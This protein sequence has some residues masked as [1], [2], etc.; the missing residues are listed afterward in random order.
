MRKSFFQKVSLSLVAALVIS[1]FHGTVLAQAAN[2]KIVKEGGGTAPYYVYVN[3]S[4]A[5]Y[6]LSKEDKSATYVWDIVEGSEYAAINSKTGV[7]TAKAPGY[8]VIRCTAQYDDGTTEEVTKKIRIVLRSKSISTNK[9]KDVTLLEDG[10][11]VFETVPS[12][13]TSTDVFRYTSSDESVAKVDYKTGEVT[14]VG[15]GSATIDV[16]GKA[17]VYADHDSK[18]N[19]KTSVDVQ[20]LPSVVKDVAQLKSALKADGT[21]TIRIATDAED[22]FTIPQREYSEKSLVVNAPNAD[23]SNY[24]TFKEVLIEDIKPTTWYENGIGNVLRCKAPNAGI[25]AGINSVVKGIIAELRDQKINI[26]VNG[27]LEFIVVSEKSSINIASGSANKE[28]QTATK[29]LVNADDAK[30]E[31]STSIELEL[32]SNAEIVLEKGAEGTKI[33]N[34]SSNQIKASIKNNTEVE[35]KVSD[36]TGKEV[37]IESGK[38]EDV[39]LLPEPDKATDLDEVNKDLADAVEKGEEEKANP[40]VTPTPGE[41][42]PTPEPTATPTVTPAP[43]NGGS[44]PVTPSKY[45]K[46]VKAAIE[47]GVA[48]YVLP[49]AITELDS[50]IVKVDTDRNGEFESQ[51]TITGSIIK[52]IGEL[53]DGQSKYVEMW[54]GL[55]GYTVSTAVDSKTITISG[56]AGSLTKTVSF[57]G[58]SYTVTVKEESNAITLQ[59]VGGAA[60]YT[61]SKSGTDTLII[62][63]G[64]EASYNS[65]EFYV[66]YTK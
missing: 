19:R 7:V 9:G 43:D 53:L 45:D 56:Q 63:G 21:G 41:T 12:P 17:N 47:N 31:S 13:E 25:I 50:A 49:V 3:G 18:Y 59:K 40:T 5:D 1:S 57:D 6:A 14:A 38:S 65:V 64:D 42:T 39:A 22:S 29:V 30:I 8:V 2:T 11:F 33:V 66:T 24:G 27:S 54:K 60:T 20:V 55:T 10:S 62:S 28:D 48:K 4:K 61:L 23:V 36:S 58:Q 35:V 15:E 46:T 34:T 26:K 32:N 52:R 44:T 16:I 37:T 51:Y